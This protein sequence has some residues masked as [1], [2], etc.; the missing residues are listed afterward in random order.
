MNDPVYQEASEALAKHMLKEGAGLDARLTCGAR[1]VLSRDLTPR[2]LASLR[3][4]FQKI[5]KTP[6]LIE[7]SA[8]P[9]KSKEL[10]ALTSVASVLF[11]LDTALTR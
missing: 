5:M 11:N 8:T 3:A 6:T 4:L 9:G 2:E 10:T 7:A 1:L